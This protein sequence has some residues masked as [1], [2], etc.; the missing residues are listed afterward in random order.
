M[1]AFRNG[2]TD[3]NIAILIFKSSYNLA[4]LY[5]NL[6]N[7][8][9]VTPESTKVKDV[10]PVVSFFKINLSGKL[11]QDPLNQFLP[12]FHLMVAI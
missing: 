1:I 10:H 12:N 8:G 5:V 4:T 9:P 7:F 11:S 3:C 2:V 6:V